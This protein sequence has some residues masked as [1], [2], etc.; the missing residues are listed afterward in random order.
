[1]KKKNAVLAAFVVT[2]GVLTAGCG[3]TS[4]ATGAWEANENSIYVTKNLEVESALLYTSEKANELYTQEG[5]ETFAKEAVSAYNVEQ[6]AAEAS[7]NTQ[8]TQLPV[9]LKSCKLEGQ[10]GTLVFDY[11]T[12]G[13]FVKF[14]QATGDNTNTVTAL[15]VKKVADEVAAGGFGEAVFLTGAGEQAELSAVEKQTGSCVVAV[16]GAATV[17]TEGRITFV[18]EG[19]TVKADNAAVTPEGKSYIVFQ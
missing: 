13:D 7:E 1:M 4:Q 10:T 3:Q 15:T 6:G 2:V 5:L 14:A 17:Y 8:D 9:A 19:V 18:T 16:E 11:G 12:P